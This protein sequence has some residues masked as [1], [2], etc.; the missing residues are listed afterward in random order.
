MRV[1][2]QYGTDAITR[3]HREIG[4][5]LRNK[6]MRSIVQALLNPSYMD[7]LSTARD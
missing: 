7:S 5:Q 2:P 6:E 4:L 1:E 3:A